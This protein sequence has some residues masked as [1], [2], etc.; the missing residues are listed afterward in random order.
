MRNYTHGSPWYRV[1]LNKQGEPI[2]PFLHTMDFLPAFLWAVREQRS[3]PH[4]TIAIENAKTGERLNAR[5][6]V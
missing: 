3:Y 5:P 1:I 4:L 2:S 6:Y